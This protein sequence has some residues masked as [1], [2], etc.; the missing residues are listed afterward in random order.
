[1]LDAVTLDYSDCLTIQDAICKETRAIGDTFPTNYEELSQ[2]F[3][4]RGESYL[5]EG[6]YENAVS[7][8]LQATS[9]LG[10]INPKN[11]LT[12]AFRTE[13]GKIISYDNLAMHEMA[14][15]ALEQFQTIVDHMICSDCLENHPCQDNAISSASRQSFQDLV[16]HCKHS[17]NEGQTQQDNY[18]DILAPNPL[19]SNWCMEVV[20]GTGRSMEVIALLAPNHAIKAAL[21]G[22]IEMLTQRAIKC[23]QTGNFWKACV[24]PICRKWREWNNYK[25]QELFPNDKNLP[26]YITDK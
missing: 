24:A 22:I 4:A 2:L 5:F 12:L 14:L 8:F 3:V 21:V 15:E 6:Q 10:N 19:P 26:L 20:A 9:L 1:M 25:T 11:A 17:K 18:S 7:D 23:C 16:I 13:F